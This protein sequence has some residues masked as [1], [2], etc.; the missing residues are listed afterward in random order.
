MKRSTNSIWITRIVPAAA[1]GG[2]LK[3]IFRADD[4]AWEGQAADCW[5]M[6]LPGFEPVTCSPFSKVQ[7]GVLNNE[8]GAVF[9]KKFLR[10]GWRDAI[11]EMFRLSRACRAWRG[12]LLMEASGFSAPHVRCLIRPDGFRQNESMLITDEVA[13]AVSVKKR[14]LD[15]QYGLR[16]GP[17]RF[18]FIRAVARA[19][20]RL[21]GA[22]LYH[23]DL[24]TNNILSREKNGEWEFIWLDNERN[25][26]YR[27]LPRRKR[28]HN[29]M[30]FNTDREPSLA[31]R[32]CFWRAYARAAGLGGEDRIRTARWI[33][34][35]T[36][37]RWIRHGFMK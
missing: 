36:R 6:D 4:P 27:K 16:E 8:A 31:D 24:R 29:L 3:A 2:R 30:Q 25:R 14:L 12:N 34:A 1:G 28:N 10:R 7:R 32:L 18:A 20:A 26:K 19:A 13:G 11:K 37:A 35:R 5:E 9:L 22:G 23:G 21:H 17:H 15:P 33:R